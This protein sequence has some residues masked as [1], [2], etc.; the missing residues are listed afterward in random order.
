[1]NGVTNGQYPTDR[2]IKKRRRRKTSK[3]QTAQDSSEYTE[4]ESDSCDEEKSKVH[5]VP[6]KSQTNCHNTE[7]ITKAVVEEIA[8]GVETNEEIVLEIEKTQSNVQNGLEEKIEDKKIETAS[9]EIDSATSVDVEENQE[10][11]ASSNEEES[12]L[13]M[14]QPAPE[15][16]KA[17][18]DEDK[19][20]N[21]SSS[22][23][24]SQKSELKPDA[25][26]FVPRA[27]RTSDIPLSPNVQFIKVPP[28]FVPIPMVSLGDFNGQNF[29]PAFIPPGIPVNFLPPDPKIFP[30]FVGF[31]PNTSFVPKTDLGVEKNQSTNT[32]NPSNQTEATESCDNSTT[33]K[34]DIAHQN[35]DT[36]E[37][38]LVQNVN[39][40]IIDIATIVSKLEEAVKEQEDEDAKKT[41]K[42]GE[43]PQTSPRRKY[44]ENKHFRTNQKY[45]SNSNYRRN[46]SNPQNSPQN[47]RYNHNGDVGGHNTDTTM[48]TCTS[49]EELSSEQTLETKNI[50]LTN[51]VSPVEAKDKVQGD[52]KYQRTSPEKARKNWKQQSYQG[53]PKWH[54]N[55]VVKDFRVKNNG[56][57]YTENEIRDFKAKSSGKNYSETLKNRTQTPTVEQ[58][59]YNGDKQGKHF[60]SPK[61]DVKADPLSTTANASPKQP[62][63]WISVSNRKKRKNKNVEESD[64]SFTDH[65]EEEQS[66][67]DLFESYDVNQL[68]DVVP[69]KTEDDEEVIMVET[70]GEIEI[71]DIIHNITQNDTSL[72]GNN[73]LNI[74]MRSVSEI[75]QELLA[76]TDAMVPEGVVQEVETVSKEEVVIE[77]RLIEE[78]PE[79]NIVSAQ[80]ETIKSKGKKKSKKGTQKPLAKRIMI[81]D[82]D[83]SMSCE[84]IKTPIKKPVAK[85]DEKTEEKDVII[86]TTEESAITEDS[87]KN[88]EEDEK[89]KNKKKKKKPLKT[90]IS[91]SSLSSSNTTIN[92]VEDSYDFLLDSALSDKSVEKTNI[93]ISQELDKIIQKGMYSSLEE[94]MRSLNIDESDGF[95]KSI[96]STISSRESSIEKTAFAKSPDLSNILQNTT[97]LCKPCSVSQENN[98]E[99]KDINKILPALDSPV[100]DGFFLENPDLKEILHDR[101]VTKDT[102]K[103][104]TKIKDPNEDCKTINEEIKLDIEVEPKTLYPITQA[105]K[106]WMCKTR[107]TTPDVEILKSPRAIYK[108]FCDSASETD[109]QLSESKSLL[110]ELNVDIGDE[111]VTI[112]SKEERLQSTDECV[113]QS[114]LMECWE[115]DV[116]VCKNANGRSGNGDSKCFIEKDCPNSHIEQGGGCGRSIR[117]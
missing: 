92:V 73:S 98:S 55:G 88:C 115:P 34:D 117:K 23:V 105:V 27:Y 62:N 10:N 13:E 111:E 75:E 90:T 94:K 74:S 77:G 85:L 91:S 89:K 99:N 2:R 79:L 97:A 114:D 42:D 82:V 70:T 1:M 29:S 100:E 33:A 84:E 58:K 24:K 53:S 37:K 66:Q 20:Q 54:P 4:D 16:I 104:E 60:E 14:H 57:I 108:E 116:E 102:E 52:G 69:T 36:T 109:T 11:V 93:E 28:N 106:E 25:E 76:K 95:F 12:K 61:K 110:E 96:F 9:S 113:E 8:N 83:L 80:E 112:F 30:N 26:E 19:S 31:V 47:Y 67:I 59:Y 64:A 5:S 44:Y 45:K 15:M 68:V 48:E 41:N 3:S 49:K 101:T 65:V 50:E 21:P 81:T 43:E 63:Q 71:A 103:E 39:S 6:S 17:P 35:D 38:N 87:S 78:L 40:K 7:E 51:G 46:Y 18:A 22:C 56:K 32:G 86:L 107:E 72:A